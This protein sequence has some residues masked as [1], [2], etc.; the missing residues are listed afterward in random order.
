METPNIRQMTLPATWLQ[1]P[2]AAEALF[3]FETGIWTGEK[4]PLVECAVIRNTNFRNDGLL[5]L[6]N[7]AY[8]PIEARQLEKKR[9]KPGDIIIERSGGGPQQ[10]VG[11]VVFFNLDAGSFCFSNFTSRLRVE[12]K[13]AVDP[14]YLHL[15]LYYF[16]ISGQTEPLQRRTTGIRNLAFNDYKN[17][18][19]PLPPLSEQRSIAYA[20]RAIQDAKQ[21]RRCEIAL[22]RER[23]AA[24]MQYLFTYGT[25]GERTKQT[26]IG[27]MPQSWSIV[28]LGELADTRALLI[29]NGYAQGGYNEAGRGVPHIRPFNVTSEGEIDL[30]QIKSIEP[31]TENSPYWLHIGDVIFNNTNSE[32]LVGKT[33]YFGQTGK[34]VLSNHM[35]IVRVLNQSMLDAYWLAKQ[36]H[37][38]WQLGLFLRLRRRHVNQASVGLDR[39]RGVALGLPALEEQ[40]QIAVILGACDTKL[41]AL[42][43]ESI[44]LDELFRAMLEELM[45]GRLS[46]LPLAEDDYAYMIQ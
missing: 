30:T 24:L 29:R 4:P 33:A 25:H 9:L 32:E 34:Y 5:D 14:R 39:L 6:S 21:A 43:K 2:L 35:T 15:F 37:Y 28:R 42:E 8:I 3:S 46:A 23:K 22:E 31:P 11:R 36:L 38:L 45:T 40:Q 18:L 12:D 13:E 27:E 44:L 16:H 26:E 1:V 17:S 20:L 7:V 10:P 41:A 19:V